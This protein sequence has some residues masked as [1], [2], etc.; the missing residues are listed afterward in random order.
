[1]HKQTIK[2]ALFWT[3]ILFNTVLEVPADMSM[4]A[5]IF[6]VGV[7]FMALYNIIEQAREWEKKLKKSAKPRNQKRTCKNKYILIVRRVEGGCQDVLENC[8]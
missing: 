2:D 6:G 4:L 5:Q 8:R 1:M 7:I 3:V